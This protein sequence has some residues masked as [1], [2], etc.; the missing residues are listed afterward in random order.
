MRRQ[1]K[2]KSKRKLL[3][4]MHTLQ[5]RPT[6]MAALG[7]R[8]LRTAAAASRRAFFCEGNPSPRRPA[9]LLR[10]IDLLLQDVARSTAAVHS[11]LCQ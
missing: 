2:L 9:A 6:L 5:Q 4:S 10:K 3:P 1:E 8:T 11:C 7:F